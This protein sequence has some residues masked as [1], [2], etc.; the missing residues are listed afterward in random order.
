M[1]RVLQVVTESPM[2]LE[3]LSQKVEQTGEGRLRA[4]KRSLGNDS[5][6]GL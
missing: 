6:Q 3:S 5:F 2:T 1:G 4:R